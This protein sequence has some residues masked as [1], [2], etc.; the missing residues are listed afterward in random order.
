[1]KLNY[2]TPK[3]AEFLV[4]QN[5][6]KGQTVVVMTVSGSEFVGVAQCH[7]GNTQGVK[8]DSWDKAHG[9]MIATNRALKKYWDQYAM[10]PFKFQLAEFPSGWGHVKRELESVRPTG[11]RFVCTNTLG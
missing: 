7:P 9:E 1:M 8:P 6:K 3:G 2:E 4:V 11:I 5:K 10:S